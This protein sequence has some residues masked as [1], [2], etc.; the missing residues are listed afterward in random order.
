MDEEDLV[1]P[2]DRSERYIIIEISIF[3]GRSI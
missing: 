2:Q 1:Y 3:E